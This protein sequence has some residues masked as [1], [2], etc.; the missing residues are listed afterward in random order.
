MSMARTSKLWAPAESGAE[1][2]WLAPG[3][4]QGT[5]AWESKRQAKLEP[6]S[7][8]EKAKVGVASA[9]DP[10]GPEVMVVSG[11]TVSTVKERVTIALSLPGASIALTDKVWSPFVSGIVRVWGEEQAANGAES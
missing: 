6:D 4:E 10:E 5:K 3:P 1:G 8:E 7:L 11:A 9:V 2:V